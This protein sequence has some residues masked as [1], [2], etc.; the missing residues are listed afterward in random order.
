MAA[1]PGF[2]ALSSNR[3]VCLLPVL[4]GLDDTL[5]KE[6]IGSQELRISQGKVFLTRNKIQQ[7]VPCLLFFVKEGEAKKTS[8]ELEF[9]EPA[10]LNLTVCSICNTILGIKKW[11]GR[12]AEGELYQ[13]SST[14]K[15]IMINKA[16]GSGTFNHYMTGDQFS[17]WFFWQVVCRCTSKQFLDNQKSSIFL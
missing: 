2:T 14:P 4:A 17:Q 9:V 16:S 6:K 8:W 3:L 11:L 5:L 1:V 13:S 10:T 15:I 7:V 12:E